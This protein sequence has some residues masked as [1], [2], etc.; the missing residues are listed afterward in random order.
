[1]EAA[2]S[3]VTLADASFRLIAIIRDIRSSDEQRHRLLTEINSLWL[4]LE[5][6]KSQLTDQDSDGSQALTNHIAAL[7]TGGGI[8]HDINELVDELIVRLEDKVGRYD[9][10]KQRLRW[11]WEE[12]EFEKLMLRI[13]GLRDSLNLALTSTTTNMLRKIDNRTSSIQLSMDKDKLVALL[14]WLSPYNFVK[15]QVPLTSAMLI[16]KDSD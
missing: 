16:G 5:H 6:V 11:V 7:D 10:I 1:M 9:R 13:S 8:L 2:A 12:K 14:E 3:V 15:Q 4:V